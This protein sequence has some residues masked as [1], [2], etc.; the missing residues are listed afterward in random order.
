MANFIT[1]ECK[2]CTM[3]VKVCPVN[4]IQGEK[5]QVHKINPDLCIEC[6]ACGRICAYSAVNNKDGILIKNIKRP[7]WAKPV[8]DYGRCVSCNICV[9][10]CPTGA[11]S[12]FPNET[13]K[14][15]HLHPGLADE[16]AC[17]SC[18]FCVDNCPMDAIMLLAPKE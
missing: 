3:C 5:K 18:G 12:N 6:D 7:L 17:F 13:K 11:I 16:A 1:N 15:S 8:W 4:A 10:A 14:G 9:Q 2:G